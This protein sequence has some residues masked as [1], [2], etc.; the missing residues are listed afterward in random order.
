[1]TEEQEFA[2]AAEAM[3]DLIAKV[4][5]VMLATSSSGGAPSASYAPVFVDESRNLYVYVSRLARHF[6]YLSR[7]GRASALLIEDEC[8]AENLFARKRLTLDCRVE[9]IERGCEEWELLMDRAT[10]RLG[11]TLGYL[12]GMTDFELFRL[13]ADAGRLVLGFGKAYQAGGDRL[14]E[15]GYVSSSGH[16]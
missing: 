4:R 8:V 2:E 12:R 5:S 16:R 7:Q 1:M 3:S 6:A 10:S 11:D 13:R 9:L 14:S 15:V